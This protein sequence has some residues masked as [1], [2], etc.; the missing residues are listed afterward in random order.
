MFLGCGCVLSH[1]EA[2][3]KLFLLLKTRHSL[4]IKG[5]LFHNAVVRVLGE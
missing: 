3:N 5:E 1:L 4:S 2:Q